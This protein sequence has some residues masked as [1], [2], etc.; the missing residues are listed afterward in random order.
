MC[1]LAM[2]RALNCCTSGNVWKPTQNIPGETVSSL[3]LIQAERICQVL[4]SSL[5]FASDRVLCYALC[6]V[7]TNAF[8]SNFQWASLADEALSNFSSDSIL[9]H[10]T[11]KSVAECEAKIHSKRMQLLSGLQSNVGKTLFW[12]DSHLLPR[13]ELGLMVC[14]L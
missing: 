3:P 8:I 1:W 6:L 5:P 12:Q 4:S 11:Y 2:N 13:E 10:F 14:C 7:T 9:F